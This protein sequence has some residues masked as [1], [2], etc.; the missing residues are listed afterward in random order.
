MGFTLLKLAAS[1]NNRLVVTAL[2]EAGADPK[3]ILRIFGLKTP[4]GCS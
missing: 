4:A 3:S 1:N 2:F